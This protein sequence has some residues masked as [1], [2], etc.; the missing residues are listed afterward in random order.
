MSWIGRYTGLISMFLSLLGSGL[1]HLQSHVVNCI[2]KFALPCRGQMVSSLYVSQSVGQ[3]WMLVESVQTL[4][5]WIDSV[6]KSQPKC[7]QVA[8]LENADVVFLAVFLRYLPYCLSYF[9]FCL[10]YLVNLYVLHSILCIE[11]L[12]K[13]I[14]HFV[15]HYYQDPG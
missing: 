4:L 5:G 2:K 9:Q 6:K 12:L 8:C 14:F 15:A 3:V 7:N 10:V 1:P 11:I 13:C